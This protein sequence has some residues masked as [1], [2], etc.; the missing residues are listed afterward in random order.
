[1]KI[2]V[3]LPMA[4]DTDNGYVPSYL[5]IR[6]RALQAEEAGFDSVWLFD[7]LIFR[8]P[9]EPVGGIWEVWTLL[10]A[11]A[12]ATQRVELGT[13]VLCV[14][15]RIPAVLAKMAD[16]LDEVSGGRLILGLGAGW[17]QPEF[18]AFG[19]PFDHRAAR[20]EEALQIIVPLLK[21][22]SVDFHGTYYSASHCELRP[23][24]PRPS[25][26]PILVASH[27]QRMLRATAKYADCWNT[28]WL[29]RASALP[30]RRA[31]LEAAC[32][33]V[34]R[35]PATLEVTVGVSVSY[36][37]AAEGE[38]VD[39][40]RQL[41][42]TPEE[43]AAALHEYEAAGVGHVI[44]SLQPETP[45]SLEKLARALQMYREGQPARATG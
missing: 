17:H 19:V 1:M 24:G 3:V 40:Q 7:H 41:K 38:T 11:L 4:E 39:P 16:T 2:G 43:V 29:G 42:G 32:A 18:D 9:D 33:D 26:P 21:K 27:G 13:I 22:G 15:F 37:E 30:E 25:G 31:R 14:P 28:A 35:D 12:D 10:A 8:F 34:G 6:D 5:E 23:R 20:F 36:E 45:A 44:C